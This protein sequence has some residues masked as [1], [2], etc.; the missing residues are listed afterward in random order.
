MYEWI[1]Q[2]FGFI[3]DVSRDVS[4][5]ATSSDC[6]EW[7]D[8]NSSNNINQMQSQLFLVIFGAGGQ[9]GLTRRRL[10]NVCLHCLLTPVKQ[11]QSWKGLSITNTCSPSESIIVI[12]SPQKVSR[13]IHTT[14]KIGVTCKPLNQ[15]IVMN[16]IEH[17]RSTSKTHN[18]RGQ[19]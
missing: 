2:K 18:R 9:F 3:S 13:F 4:A 10:S 12:G 14:K 1:L 11:H 8:A 15:R 5:C 17:T 7:H 16:P 19:R 6:F